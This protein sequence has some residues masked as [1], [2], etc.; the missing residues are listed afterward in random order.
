MG[1][2]VNDVAHYLRSRTNDEKRG[3][4]KWMRHLEKQNKEKKNTQSCL[5]KTFEKITRKN[6]LK[7]IER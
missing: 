5:V 1:T 4:K 6:S 7:V 3:A 2:G